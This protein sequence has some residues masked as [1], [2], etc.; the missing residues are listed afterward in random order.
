MFLTL[1]AF[2][3]EEITDIDWKSS[4][5]LFKKNSIKEI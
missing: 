2:T 4:C 5:M 1:A 3:Y